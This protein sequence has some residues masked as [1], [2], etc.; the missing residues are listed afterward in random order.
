MYIYTKEGSALKRH[1]L[2]VGDTIPAN[3]VWIDLLNLTPE[4]EKRVEAFL[5]VDIPTREEMHEIEVSSRLY[6]ENGGIYMTAILVTNS[7]TPEPEM[8]AFTFII[9]GERLVTL[10]Y[11]DPQ[12]FRAFSSR[13][14]R[15]PAAQHSGTAMYVGLVE[16]IVTR[17]ADILEQIGQD[18]DTSTQSIFRKPAEAGKKPDYQ[19]VLVEIGRTGD[20]ISKTRES[21]VTMSRMVTYAT[22]S[23]TISHGENA[24]RLVAIAKDV[25]ALSDHASFLS[26]K[27]TFLLDATLGMI[28]MEQNNIIK[29]FSVAAVT[30][31]PPTLIASIYGMNFSHMPELSWKTGYPL[32]L[33]LMVLSA[34]LPYKY[35]KKKNWL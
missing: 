20:L 33:A 6:H 35:F 31:L 1:D 3:T 17:I 12:P 2:P 11:S 25:T 28:G 23:E 13:A 22:Q 4:E 7:D 24:S 5:N 26:N 18:A 29:I 21:L 15:L 30:F 10:R 27:V 9:V 16:T 32:A 34:W 19:S 8:H 14:E